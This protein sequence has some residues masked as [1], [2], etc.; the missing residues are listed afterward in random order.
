MGNFDMPDSMV[1]LIFAE[2]ALIYVYLAFYLN[3]QQHFHSHPKFQ[4][5]YHYYTNKNHLIRKIQLKDA[6]LIPNLGSWN[7]IYMGLRHVMTL[8]CDITNGIRISIGCNI[9]IINIYEC[10]KFR[11]NSHAVTN[12]INFN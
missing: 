2:I 8:M 7:G 9:C 6:Y 12:Q 4:W 5:E 10:T 3:P 1:A 11:N